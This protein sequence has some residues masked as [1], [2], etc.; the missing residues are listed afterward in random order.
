LAAWDVH[1]AVVFGPCEQS[2]GKA[3]FG[4]LVDDV[5]GQEP[6]RSA[7]RVFWVVDTGSSHRGE[8]AAAE[9]REH[10]PRI[11][12]VHTP[13]HASWL[14]QIEIYFSI[15]QRKV[16][17]PNDCATLDELTDRTVAFG[18]RYSAFN[19]PFAWRFTRQALERRLRD[20]L[21]QPDLVTP[22]A[23]AGQAWVREPT[24]VN[25]HDFPGDAL[26]RTVSYGG[27]RPGQQP[28]TRLPRQVR[29][30]ASLRRRRHRGL[31]ANRWANH[32]AQPPRV[33]NAGRWRWQQQ[34]PYAGMEGTRAGAAV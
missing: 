1:R 12:M 16:L 28:R 4:R 18:K 6:Y 31:V 19:N 33:A 21:I 8:R 32:L 15:L 10:Y 14:N 29:R 13:V 22:L 9:L 30:H 27:V 24:A 20:A 17:T 23:N 5:M 34:L 2:T 3:A 26:G 25:V 11:V 7:R